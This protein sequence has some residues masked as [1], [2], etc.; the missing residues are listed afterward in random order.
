MKVQI[1]SNRSLDTSNNVICNLKKSCSLNCFVSTFPPPFFSSSS[2]PSNKMK[3]ERQMLHFPRIWQA[4][5][6][7]WVIDHKSS[8]HT[9]SISPNHVNMFLNEP[10]ILPSAG[11]YR[12][13]KVI[14]F[15]Q[16]FDLL[17]GFLHFRLWPSIYLW[18]AIGNSLKKNSPM[19]KSSFILR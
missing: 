5:L 11:S 3:C 8:P 10:G 6:V 18:T 12:K 14:F 2:P 16:A 15:P 13:E 17:L 1:I 9:L 4:F 19:K 7:C